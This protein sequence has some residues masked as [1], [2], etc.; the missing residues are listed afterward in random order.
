MIEVL[1]K[2]LKELDEMRTNL[3]QELV[4]GRMPSTRFDAAQKI[5]EVSTVICE[6]AKTINQIGEK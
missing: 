5:I 1:T 2:Q 3:C 6:T 4:Q